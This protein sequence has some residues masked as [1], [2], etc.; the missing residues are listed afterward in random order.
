MPILMH[1]LKRNDI[2]VVILNKS[3]ILL[4]FEVL[5]H[6]DFFFIRDKAA[7]IQYQIDTI[8]R[9]EDFKHLYK[10]HEAAYRQKWSKSAK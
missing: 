10:I 7:R 3:P 1:E 9:H 5:R 6:G 2:D 4:K 8:N